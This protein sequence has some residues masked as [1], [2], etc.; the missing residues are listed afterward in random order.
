MLGLC[1]VKGSEGNG[2]VVNDIGLVCQDCVVAVEFFPH[3]IKSFQD[4]GLIGL[5][6]ILLDLGWRF[7]DWGLC[8]AI[9]R[10]EELHLGRNRG[11]G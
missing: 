4:S 9:K 3:A 5:H 10:V 7:R 6:S 2:V 11:G 8:V 1:V